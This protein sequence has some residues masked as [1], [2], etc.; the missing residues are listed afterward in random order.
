MLSIKQS[1]LRWH[2]ASPDPG[3]EAVQRRRRRRENAVF[4]NI[5]PHLPAQFFGHLWTSAGSQR[6]AERE[7]LFEAGDVLPPV[8][9]A[10]RKVCS[11]SALARLEAMSASSPSL[12]RARLSASSRSLMGYR[13]RP[14]W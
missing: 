2:L 4:F 10:S 8:V 6:L 1:L 11:K 3:T 12:A 7:V 9:I 13:A 14:L 5:L